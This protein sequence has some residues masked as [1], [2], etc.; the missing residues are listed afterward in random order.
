MSAAGK[1]TVKKVKKGETKRKTYIFFILG[2]ALC[3]LQFTLV[4]FTL[5]RSHRCLAGVAHVTLYPDD[6]N[7]H[8]TEGIRVDSATDITQ[9]MCSTG[10]L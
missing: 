8:N 10:D 1:K 2:V 5:S 6:N 4:H 9:L 7:I 3:Y